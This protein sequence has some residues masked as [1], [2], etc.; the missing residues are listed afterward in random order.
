MCP[1]EASGVQKLVA[2]SMS[3]LYSLRCIFLVLQFKDTIS[4]KGEAKKH[5][6]G[7]RDDRTGGIHS[8]LDALSNISVLA[9]STYFNMWI[10][11][12]SE[13]PLDIVLNGLAMEFIAVFDDEIYTQYTKRYPKTFDNI[14]ASVTTKAKPLEGLVGCLLFIFYYLPSYFVVRTAIVLSPFVA[15]SEIA[16]IWACK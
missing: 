1:N 14:K 12:S 3:A 11:Y 5:L 9:M 15:A 16:Y 13:E 8:Q 7:Y 4:E 10:I 2:M 6:P